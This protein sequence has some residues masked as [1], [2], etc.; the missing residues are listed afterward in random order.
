MNAPVHTN[1]HSS[2]LLPISALVVGLDEGHLL[3]DC[4]KSLSFC[5]ERVYIDLGSRDDSVE[6][7][8]SLGW[9][10]EIHERVPFVEIIHQKLSG[11]LKYDWVLYLDPDERAGPATAA[12]IG[13]LVTM[14]EGSQVGAIRVPCDYYFKRKQIMGTP[15]GSANT[16][17]FVVNKTRVS[18]RSEVHRGTEINPGFHEEQLDEDGLRIQHFWSDSWK[19]LLAKH[20]RYLKSE[21]VSKYSA[22]RRTSLFTVL[23]TPW[24]TLVDTIRHK[25]PFR[26]GITG[27]GLSCLW[28]IYKSA[29]EWALLVHQSRVKQDQNKTPKPAS[30]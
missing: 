6:I 26:D 9:N 18:F 21:G 16:R 4:L 14:Q 29:A 12:T 28:V 8:L 10:A 1:F 19:S 15:W 23:T 22:G 13:P 2:D 30:R 20:V 17:R 5:R 3:S 24:K 27:I 7:A 25:A 11:R